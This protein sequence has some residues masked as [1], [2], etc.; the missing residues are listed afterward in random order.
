MARRETPGTV[1]LDE[2][3]RHLIIR[4]PFNQYLVDEVKGI[5]G[6]RWDPAK[7]QWRVP[8]HKA[9]EV[10]GT[11]SKHNFMFAPEVTM[12][13]AGTIAVPSAKE[14]PTADGGENAEGGDSGSVDSDDGA[15][16]DGPA[17]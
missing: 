12:I 13:L 14:M 11:F 1:E 15:S 10:F 7:K 17:T 3:R 8:A 9:E 6:R 2:D 4:F 16:E 5:T